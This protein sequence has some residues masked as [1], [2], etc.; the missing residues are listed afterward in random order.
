MPTARPTARPAARPTDWREGCAIRLLFD[1][2]C[3]VC[4]REMRLLER[5]DRRGRLEFEDIAD[6]SFDPSRYGLEMDQVVGSMHAVLPDGSIV[7]G[8]EVFRRAYDAV[9]LGWLLAPTR[10][11][12]V[13]PLA[14]LAYR[15]F[16]K[17]RPR[18]SRFDPADCDGG[19]CAVTPRETR[20]SRSTAVAPARER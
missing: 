10:W 17:I 15:A 20:S 13:R 11:P 6:A 3:P 19:R 16:A 5:L 12:L 9:G 8:V 18:L 2:L 1:G 7:V 4:A 14:D